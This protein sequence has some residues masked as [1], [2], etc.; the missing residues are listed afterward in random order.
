[1]KKI[2][3]QINWKP[4]FP[5]D[6]K[7]RLNFSMMLIAKRRSG[8]TELIKYF[9]EKYWH[10]KYDLVL[11]Y[12]T[13]ANAEYYKQWIKGKRQFITNNDLDKI[14]TAIKFNSNLRKK[15]RMPVNTLVI[16]DDT[17]SR[18]QKFDEDILNLYTKGRHYN[19]SIVYSSQTPTLVDNIWKENSDFIFIF[20][21]T[22]RRYQEYVADN[23]I[24]GT[25]DVSFDSK[26]KERNAYIDLLKRITSKKYRTLVLDMYKE[27]IFQFIANI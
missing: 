22:T 5:I 13:D 24:S 1:M 7:K 17:V 10:D 21:M 9:Y 2:L 18:K 26:I 3:P 6:S 23:I 16:F 11:V 19:L 27:G 20:K 15:N 25:L 4:D 14:K 8:K 12:T